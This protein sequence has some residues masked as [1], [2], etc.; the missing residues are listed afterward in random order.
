MAQDVE[1]IRQLTRSYRFLRGYEFIPAVLFFA[2]WVV[3]PWRRFNGSLRGLLFI[4]LLA[5]TI[6]AFFAIRGYYDRRFGVVEPIRH[7]WERWLGVSIVVFVALQSVSRGFGLPVQ[8]GFLYLGVACAIYAVRNFAVERQRLLFAAVLIIMSVWPIDSLRWPNDL[9][10]MITFPGTLIV[11]AIWDHL[12]LV[13]LF[14]RA[15]G[16]AANGAR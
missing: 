12:T 14:E 1:A 7:G 16:A 3:V 15:R 8:L 2:T 9:W 4:L 6:S 10:A 5:V 11:M 13:K